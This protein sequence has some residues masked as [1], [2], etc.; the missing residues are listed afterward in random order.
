MAG[1]F[2]HHDRSRFECFAFSLGPDSADEMRARVRRGVDH[3]IDISARSD[4]ESMAMARRAGI[5]IAVDLSGYT[6]SPRTAL[7]AGRVAP[8][9]VG[10]LGYLGTMGAD[11]VDYL[12]ADDTLIE[13]EQYH[14][15]VELMLTSRFPERNVTF[16]NLGWSG[17]TPVGESR[18]ATSARTSS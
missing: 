15:W 5:E 1:V 11:H 9:Q 13:R 8:I 18:L 6:G 12:I 16:R 17:D 2:E 10:Y 3:F 14:G 7:F 4:S